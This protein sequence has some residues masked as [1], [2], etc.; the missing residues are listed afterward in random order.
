MIV[1]FTFIF[2]G[3]KLFDLGYDVDAVPLYQGISVPKMFKKD[4]KLQQYGNAACRCFSV[5]IGC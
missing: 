1:C 4:L 5:E 2:S 3:I